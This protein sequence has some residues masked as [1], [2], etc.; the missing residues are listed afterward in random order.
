MGGFEDPKDF[1]GEE[2]ND[3]FIREY[4]PEFTNGWVPQ[5]LVVWVDVSPW[6]LSGVFSGSSRLFSGV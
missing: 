2:C 4:T 3:P 5:K 6:N 1:N